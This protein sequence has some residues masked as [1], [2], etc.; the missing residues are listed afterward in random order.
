[1]LQATHVSPSD[2]KPVLG[3]FKSFL[4]AYT[5]PSDN[6]SRS[7]QQIRQQLAA[8]HMQEPATAGHRSPATDQHTST[9]GHQQ[10][11]GHT[12]AG[13]AHWQATRPSAHHHVTPGHQVAAQATTG[14]RQ[15]ANPAKSRENQPC[16]KCQW[17][18]H[19]LHLYF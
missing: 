13:C 10:T 11:P 7:Q 19:I 9:A 15:P 5:A 17:C 6:T 12:L 14:Q 3:C 2:N 4:G 16:S 8:G 1:M 18:L